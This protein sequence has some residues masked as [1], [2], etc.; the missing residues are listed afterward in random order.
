MIKNI[1]I[2]G[3]GWYGLYTALLLQNKYNVIILEKN[4]EIF[5]NSS[6]YNQ[7]RLHLG[8]HYPRCSKTRNL[9]VNSY[10]KFINKFSIVYQ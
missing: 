4:S 2:I 5:N 1:I 3:T 6:N 10:H 8:Y 9:C 7:N